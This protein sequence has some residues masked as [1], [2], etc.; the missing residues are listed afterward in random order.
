ML[1]APGHPLVYKEAL[2]VANVVQTDVLI[3]TDVL[4]TKCVAMYKKIDY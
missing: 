4:K 3:S 1:S 2:F